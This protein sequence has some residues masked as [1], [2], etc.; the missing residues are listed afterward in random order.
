MKLKVDPE[1]EPEVETASYNVV[2]SGPPNVRILQKPRSGE[3]VVREGTE[4]RVECEVS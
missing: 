2:F 4:L 1:P 3:F